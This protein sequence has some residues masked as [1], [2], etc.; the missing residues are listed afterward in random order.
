MALRAIALAILVVCSLNRSALGLSAGD[1]FD[2]E[3]RAEH[4]SLE[5]AKTGVLS[6]GIG[7]GAVR[8]DSVV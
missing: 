8:F 3:S 2:F 6:S 1:L 4:D 5:G 7:S